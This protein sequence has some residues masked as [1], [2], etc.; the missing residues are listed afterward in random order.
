MAT[1]LLTDTLEAIKKEGLPTG[2]TIGDGLGK[3]M[4]D[5][6]IFL[7]KNKII[8]GCIIDIAVHKRAASIG[9]GPLTLEKYEPKPRGAGWTVLCDADTPEQVVAA[10]ITYVLTGEFDDV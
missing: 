5:G 4:E 10:F 3:E 8:V 6:Y 7:R 9:K 2:W 1:V